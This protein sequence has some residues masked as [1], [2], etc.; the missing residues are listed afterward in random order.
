[1]DIYCNK[2]TSQVIIGLQEFMVS[3]VYLMLKQ[4]LQIYQCFQWGCCWGCW[5]KL[6]DAFC[7][8][9]VCPF[10]FRVW[11]TLFSVEDQALKL[12]TF[13]SVV[14]SY[15]G[16]GVSFFFFSGP[17]AEA[18]NCFCGTFLFSTQSALLRNKFWSICGLGRHAPVVPSLS[19][20]RK[21]D[22]L[23]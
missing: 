7:L 5:A 4:A 13:T 14:L 16:L 19:G 18:A 3:V 10:L 22:L 1:M 11:S 9:S 23:C 15:S 17:G 2:Y 8:Q 6:W 21:K 12:L 20:T